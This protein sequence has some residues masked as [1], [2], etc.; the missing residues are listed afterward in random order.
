VIA[1]SAATREVAASST[2]I[3]KAWRC[4][5]L[6]GVNLTRPN[7]SRANVLLA[8]MSLASLI[9]ANLN[10]A[11]LDGVD[12]T[13]AYLADMYLI[14]AKSAHI[15]QTVRE[16]RLPYSGPLVAPSPWEKLGG[17]SS[18]SAGTSE[19]LRQRASHSNCF[20]P[21]TSSFSCSIS[22]WSS[23]R[24]PFLSTIAS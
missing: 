22:A 12:V 15:A 21:I 24:G 9:H 17:V 14:D 10:D 19:T 2:E 1:G 11:R 6:R 5:H 16:W 18:S 13:A 8:E 7:L 4:G 23:T 20:Q 3:L